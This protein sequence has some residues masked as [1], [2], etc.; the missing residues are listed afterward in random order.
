MNVTDI[1]RGMKRTKEGKGK[2]NRDSKR[3]SRKEK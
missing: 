3:E 2:C 1:G